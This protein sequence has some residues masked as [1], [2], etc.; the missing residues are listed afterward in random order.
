MPD[1]TGPTEDPDARPSSTVVL[2]RDADD[3][4]E[5]FIVRRHARTAFGGSYAFPGGVIEDADRRVRGH[6]RGRAASEADALLGVEADGIDYYIAAIRELFEEAGVLL[7]E[8]LPEPGRRAELRDALNDGSLAWPAL[9]AGEALDLRCDELSYFGFWI[10]PEFFDRRFS[11]RFFLATMPDCQRAAHCGTELT[12]SCWMTAA[13]I[14][15]SAAAGDFRLPPPTRRTLEQLSAHADV[16]A[17]RQ[18]AAGRCA[19][20][21]PCVF[22]TVRVASDGSQVIDYPAAT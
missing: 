8:P 10:T 14:L 7:A 9:V 16:A 17:M 21:V 12:D 22:P 5:L 19:A 3:G 18:W 13:E 20:G 1:T 15:A 6:C 2:A 11:T 4:P